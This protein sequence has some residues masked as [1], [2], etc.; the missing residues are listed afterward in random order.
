V[1]H[2]P[3]F[4]SGSDLQGTVQHLQQAIQKAR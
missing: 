1:Q 4:R 2:E 3:V